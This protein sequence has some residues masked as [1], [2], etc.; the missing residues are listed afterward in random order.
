MLLKIPKL[1]AKLQKQSTNG[2]TLSELLV[3]VSASSVVISSLMFVMTDLLS[4]NQQEQAISAIQQDMQQTLDYLTRDLREAVHIYNGDEVKERTYGMAGVSNFLPDFGDNTQIILAFWKVE[5]LPYLPSD[6]FP[7]CSTDFSND[8]DKENECENIRIERRAYSLVVY[9]HDWNNEDEEWNGESRIVRYALRKYSNLSNL[10][11]TAGYVDPMNESTF[12]RWPLSS[13]GTDLQGGT[14]PSA[15]NNTNVLVDYV[16]VPSTP[17]ETE[18]NCSSDY[19]RSPYNDP[20][21]GNDD[22]NSFFTC[23]RNTNNDTQSSFNQDTWIFLRGNANGKDGIDQD[24]PL[25]I[26]QQGVI[27]RSVIDATVPE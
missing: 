12:K 25:E 22:N 15:D 23:V 4:N 2:L 6:S 17:I 24:S 5:P 26:L 19:I 27:S 10:T 9:V 3:A 11:R 13:G 14:K 20:N 7:N 16:A 21:D 18:F 8:S 1:I